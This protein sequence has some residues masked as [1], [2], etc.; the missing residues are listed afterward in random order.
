M[1]FIKAFLASVA[2]IVSASSANAAVTNIGPVTAPYAN[3]ETFE[4]N[5]SFDDVYTFSLTG[6]A[7][8]FSVSKIVLSGFYDFS[9]LTFSVFSGTY[10]AGAELHSVF[11]PTAEEVE[12]SLS[13]LTAGDY[14]VQIAG[15]T[16]GIAGGAYSF[17]ITPV[18]EP[19]SVAMLLIGFAALGAVARRRK[20]L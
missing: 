18:P 2:L 4:A 6:P 20:T 9:S 15:T 1:N 7:A 16:S 10:G 5:T 8:D 11:V 19:S 17:S 3:I 13:S 12:F 14:Y